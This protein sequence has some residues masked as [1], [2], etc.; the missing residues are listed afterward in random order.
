METQL[1]GENAEA[2]THVILVCKDLIARR[3]GKAAAQDKTEEMQ[4]EEAEETQ[5]EQ[6]EE[7]EEDTQPMEEEEQEKDKAQ[8]SNPSWVEAAITEAVGEFS[9]MPAEAIRGNFQEIYQQNDHTVLAAFLKMEQAAEH[10][11]NGMKPYMLKLVRLRAHDFITHYVI[12]IL[13]RTLLC[14]CVRCLPPLTVDRCVCVCVRARAR[15][16]A[17]GCVCAC[18]PG[19]V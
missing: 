10:E 18:V 14:I 2:F 15:V 7:T 3:G 19:R 1:D 6:Q 4:E 16:R 11:E 5:Q 17:G 9:E 12:A 13:L 8:L